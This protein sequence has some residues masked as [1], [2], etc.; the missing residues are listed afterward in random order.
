MSERMTR[1]R[2]MQA[3]SFGS[4]AQGHT[5]NGALSLIFTQRR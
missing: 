1:N 4:N 5:Q 3:L 2:V